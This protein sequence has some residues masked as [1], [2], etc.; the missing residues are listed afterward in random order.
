MDTRSEE[1]IKRDVN[2]DIE[3]IK[4]YRNMSKKE[5]LAYKMYDNY[6]EVVGGK[7]FNGDPLPKSDEF[8]NDPNKTKQSNA[9]IVA[10]QTAI[11]F[12]RI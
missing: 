9:W 3:Y 10:A 12:F 8:F 7:A 5:E 2:E 6:C 4:K 11:D 1:Q